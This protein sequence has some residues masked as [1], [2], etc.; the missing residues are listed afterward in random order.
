MAI[1]FRESVAARTI[2]FSPKPNP[3][4]SLNDVVPLGGCMKMYCAILTRVLE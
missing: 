4:F 3:F 1:S 2:E